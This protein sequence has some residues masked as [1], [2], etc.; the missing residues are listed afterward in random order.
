VASRKKHDVIELLKALRAAGIVCSTVS[1]GGVTLDGVAW[2][3]SDDGTAKKPE[4]RLSAW[5]QQVEAI[6]SMPVN[7]KDS[8]PEEALL[9]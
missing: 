1:V 4:P 7:A 9:E 2:L 3:A 6:K 8:V 5:Q